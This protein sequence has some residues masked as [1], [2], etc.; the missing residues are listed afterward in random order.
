[1]TTPT[2][3]APRTVTL[4]KNSREELRVSVDEFRGHRLL[5][6]RVWYESDDGTLRPGKQGLA[7]RLEMAG[8]LARAIREVCDG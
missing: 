2:L 5:N 3:S 4:R 7:V 1:M 6:L 8:D